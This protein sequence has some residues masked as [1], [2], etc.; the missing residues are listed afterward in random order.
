MTRIMNVDGSGQRR[1]WSQ[2]DEGGVLAWSPDSK[3]IAFT[4][5]N[6]IYTIDLGGGLAQEVA[7]R[8]DNVDP[9]WQPTPTDRE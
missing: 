5:D 4:S 6:D 9:A 3:R 8:G 1:I 2:T 7:G